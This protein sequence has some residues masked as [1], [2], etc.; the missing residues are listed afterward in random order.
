MLTPE[1]SAAWKALLADPGPVVVTTHY[2]PDGDALGSILG[3][4]NYLR[5]KGFEVAL[6]APSDWP[7]F[8]N[9]LPGS[10]QILNYE[11]AKRTAWKLIRSAKV[12]FCLDF[13]DLDRIHAM[14]ED[15][16]KSDAQ[17]V[18]IDHHLDPKPFAKLMLSDTTAAATCELVARLIHEMGDWSLMDLDMAANLYTGIMTDTGSFRFASTTSRL[19]RLVADLMDLGLQ[20]TPLHEAINDQYTETK[21]RFLGHCYS[22]CLRHLPEQKIAYFILSAKDLKEFNT[23][24]GDTETLVNTALSLRGV[25]FAVLLTEREDRIKMSFRSKGNIPANEFA[26]RFFD[27]GGHFNAAGGHSKLS[28]AETEASLLQHLPFIQ[29]YL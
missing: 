16:E 26:S 9:F 17:L 24:T 6:I 20:P 14:R 22:H 12:I 21:L 15:L 13:N 28:L 5:K 2:K 3:W 11:T 29:Q 7:D 8:L 19:H 18:M 25:R 1:I 27:G 23:T 10:D 4:G